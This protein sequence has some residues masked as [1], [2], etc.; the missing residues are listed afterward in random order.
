MKKLSLIAM[1]E[2][3]FFAAFALILDLLPSIKLT[4]AVSVSLAMVPIF[5]IAFRWGV[6]VSFLSGF[7]WGLLQIVIGDIQPLS[8]LQLIIEYFIAFAFIGAAGLFYK[9]IQAAINHNNKKQ[10][11]LYVVLATFVGSFARYFWH[12]LAGFIY[13]G[14]YAPKGMNPVWYSFI[15]NGGTGLGAA[16]LCS[17][18]LAILVPSASR[19]LVRK[20]VPMDTRNRHAS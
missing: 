1:I 7:L 18:V 15:V 4:P 5:V 6:R 3:S 20:S 9:P 2:A 10:L 8:A 19:I 12:F 17:V 13:W 14:Q 11:I 16:V